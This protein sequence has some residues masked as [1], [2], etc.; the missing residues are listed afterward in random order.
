D[1]QKNQRQP[2]TLSSRTM[3]RYQS[4]GKRKAC[5]IKG[6]IDFIFGSAKSFYEECKIVSVLK[7]AVA[8]PMAPPEQ[9]RSRNPIKNAQ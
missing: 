1:P 2:T 9:D 5:A 3:C 8:L 7:E 6:T 4:Q